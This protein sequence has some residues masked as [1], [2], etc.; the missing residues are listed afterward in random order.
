M[1]S[2]VNDQLAAI[3]TRQ[4]KGKDKSIGEQEAE[5][6][7]ACDREG[8]TVAGVYRDKVSASTYSSK[9]RPDWDRAG[10]GGHRPR[11]LRGRR[12]Q[13]SQ[14]HDPGHALR[15]VLRISGFGE[16][17]RSMRS[18]RSPR[19]T[20]DARAA[21]TNSKRL[22]D[23][24]T[25]IVPADGK[26]PITYTGRASLGDAVSAP[27]LPMGDGRDGGQVMADMWGPVQHQAQPGL[28][29]VDHQPAPPRSV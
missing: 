18:R 6:R 17:S 15:D 29:G 2:I 25:V 22:P 4:S 26:P 27:G 13:A 7:K 8:W 5:G 23:G 28:P 24:S 20:P 19:A 1:L 16:W 9:A 12:E 11:R 21:G 10:R 14:L 3:Y